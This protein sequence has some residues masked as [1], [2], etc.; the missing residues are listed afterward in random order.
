M[1]AGTESTVQVRLS[2]QDVCV[3]SRSVDPPALLF[4]GLTGLEHVHM[5]IGRL[6][7]STLLLK[8]RATQGS[9]K[10]SIFVNGIVLYNSANLELEN[11]RNADLP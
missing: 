6:K 1:F 10:M 8:G 2:Q 7:E 5:Q 9:G 11:M 4:Q 3:G